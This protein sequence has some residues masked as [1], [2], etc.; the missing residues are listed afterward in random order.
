MVVSVKLIKV[1]LVVVFGYLLTACGDSNSDSKTY[2]RVDFSVS[3]APVDGFS[4]VR[5]DIEQVEFIHD[6]GDRT[7]HEVDRSVNLLEY[8]GT[9]SALILSDIEL[10][11]GDYKNLIIHV[12]PGSG[13]NYVMKI[14]TPGVE[15]NLKQPSNKLKLGSFTVTDE[16]VQAFTIEFDLRQALVLRGNSGS[17]NGYILKPH[18]VTIIGNPTAASLQ[19]TV[20]SFLFD[21]GSCL[22]AS[23]NYV[24]LYAGSG[25]DVTK[26]V[27]NFDVNDV[28]FDNDLPEPGS[29]APYASAP[30][31][32]ISGFYAFGYLPAGD[33]TV[34]FSCGAVGDDPVQFDDLTIPDP[35]G[36]FE[37]IT[38]LDSQVLVHDFQP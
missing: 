22:E 32:F 21:A 31:D 36:Q 14:A 6:N 15:E 5:I 1:M 35:S 34:A 30:V 20:D 19:G 2:S 8:P 12:K 7:F 28:D 37:H 16:G 38:L 27:D 18:G 29:I 9:S 17:N 26:L 10:Q 3:D 25:L 11:T 33:Y 13:L 24:Y 23:G 4:E